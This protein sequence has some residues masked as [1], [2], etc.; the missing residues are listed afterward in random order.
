MFSVTL[1]EAVSKCNRLRDIDF[2]RVSL[3]QPNT[4]VYVNM[5][6]NCSNFTNALLLLQTDDT[7]LVFVD[8]KSD[9]EK[10]SKKRQKAT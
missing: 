8:L 4:G 10:S 2:S 7:R 9:L 3:I 1:L 6:E 5:D